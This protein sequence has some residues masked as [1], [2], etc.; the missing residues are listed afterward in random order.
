[1]ENLLIRYRDYDPVKVCFLD[2][3]YVDRV[4]SEYPGYIT[5]IIQCSVQG[6]EIDVD[7]RGL[8]LDTSIEDDLMVRLRIKMYAP[9]THE[10]SYHVNLLIFN[11]QRRT[12]EHF[13]P[14]E[15]YEL[16]EA[17]SEALRFRFSHTL[18][19]FRFTTL[20]FHPQ[21]EMDDECK[22]LGLC[23][24]HVIRFA[25][26]HLYCDLKMQDYDDDD[27]YR[28]CAAIMDLYA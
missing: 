4:L 18:P 19:T 10:V 7:T 11:M 17:I 12:I 22:N 1:M 3:G 8:K 2:S 14:L 20:S 26:C 24:A 25:I 27:I 13:E 23:V 28:L 5:T 6:D 15:I 9:D 16:G 21:R